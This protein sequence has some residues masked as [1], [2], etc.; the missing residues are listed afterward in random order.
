MTYGVSELSPVA[1]ELHLC[2][3]VRE[4]RRVSV[5]QIMLPGARTE[6]DKIV[7]D[8]DAYVAETRRRNKLRTQELRLVLL[9][10]VEADLRREGEG[11]TKAQL[12]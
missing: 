1:C 12:A 8:P 11:P 10:E 7:K 5:Q 6:L 9:E 4:V 2:Q 3:D